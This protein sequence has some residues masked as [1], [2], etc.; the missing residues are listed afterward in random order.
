MRHGRQSI[1]VTKR[2]ATTTT[3]TSS[4]RLASAMFLTWALIALMGVL[5]GA[6][7][8]A[9]G[10]PSLGISLQL[11]A[12]LIGTPLALRIWP[13]L[14]DSVRTL[15]PALLTAMQGWRVLGM[16]FLFML[17]LGNL[18]AIFAIPAGIGDVLVGVIAPFLVLRIRRGTLPLATMSWFAG[19]GILDFIVAFTLGNYVN[20]TV[21]N[22]AGFA[23]MGALPLVLVPGFLVPAFTMLHI[24]AWYSY[25]EQLRE[26][27][28]ASRPSSGAAVPASVNHLAETQVGR[29]FNTEQIEIAVP[30]KLV[31]DYVS[32][33]DK[34][35][36]WATGFARSIRRNGDRWIVDTPTGDV[37]LR[38]EADASTGTVDYIMQAGSEPEI[39]AP[40]RVLPRHGGALYVFTQF[41]SPQ[42][43][44]EAF[45]LQ[46]QT[47]R[48]ELPLLKT[49]LESA[50]RARSH[51]PG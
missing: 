18:P 38:I 15:D 47:L 22:S 4:P 7:F 29:R 11:L 44:D 43:P 45:E 25:R 27:E 32:E 46:I 34:L 36:S 13:A 30:P 48:K 16:M 23:S 33:G 17:A 3:R 31:F 40:T 35:P 14:R 28:A 51:H 21:P 1:S 6:F 49:L 41:Q 37:V 20:L 19:L 2:T 10:Q 5:F 26:G 12:V 9:P 42:T 8:T 24:A 39:V 50:S